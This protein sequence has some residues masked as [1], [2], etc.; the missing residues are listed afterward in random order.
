M[1]ID[2]ARLEIALARK[3]MSL[4]DLRGCVSPC[5][6]SRI[7]AEKEVRTKTVGAVASALGVDVEEIVKAVSA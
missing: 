2:K 6:L 3:C 7:N 1:K 5:T 4:R